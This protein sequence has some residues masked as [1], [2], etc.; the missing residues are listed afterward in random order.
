ME[1]AQLLLV[2]GGG[3]IMGVV[4]GLYGLATKRD[5]NEPIRPKKLVRTVVLFAIAGSIVRLAGEPVAMDTLSRT[6]PELT[7]I[8]IVFDMLWSRMERAGYIPNRLLT[9]SQDEIGVK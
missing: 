5:A 9:R 6:L 4:Y 2:L 3:A 8:G 1:P 7:M